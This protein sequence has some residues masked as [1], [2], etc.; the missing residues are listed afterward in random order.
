M[1]AHAGWS[2]NQSY[3]VHVAVSQPASPLWP[4]LLL[5][6]RYWGLWMT[7]VLLFTALVTPFEISF[8]KQ[9]INGERP[10]ACRLSRL[11]A[12]Y[13]WTLDHS[14]CGLSRLSELC[15]CTL[16]HRPV[17]PP[18]QLPRAVP[19]EQW[20]T[21]TNANKVSF[22][23]APL[24]LSAALF[25]CNRV[26]DVSFIIDMV[27]QALMGF[28]DKKR[29]RWETSLGPVLWRYCRT[30]L[31]LDIISAAPFD[32]VAMLLSSQTLT[33]FKVRSEPHSVSWPGNASFSSCNLCATPS[34]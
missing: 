4:L 1:E 19:A 17:F 33:K 2:G 6:V 5:Q 13:D 22:R 16:G 23:S 18:V 14:A 28:W 12:F 20:Q 32:V 24:H 8:L 9:H 31:L 7:V 11:S 15:A 26:V 27:L 10:H 21:P 29:Q 25:I 3:W 30:W 34:A